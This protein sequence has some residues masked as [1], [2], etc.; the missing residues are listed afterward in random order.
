VATLV[1]PLHPQVSITFDPFLYL[2]VPLP[3]KQKVLPVFYFARE[4]HS[5]PIKVR[6]KSLTSTLGYSTESG[7]PTPL[8]V[9][10]LPQFLVSVS[11]ENSSAS[12][13]LDSLSQSVHVKPENLRL[14]E[15]CL[16]FPSLLNIWT[17]VCTYSIDNVC[18]HWHLYT[19]EYVCDCINTGF[20][21]L[22]EA[23]LKLSVGL[24]NRGASVPSHHQAL[25]FWWWILTALPSSDKEHELQDYPATCY[26]CASI[27]LFS[28]FISNLHAGLP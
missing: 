19:C 8:T 21:L 11:K 4:P 22:F 27:L 5:K 7:S 14:T 1:T 18:S 24:C 6:S 3:Q 2:P 17:C 28:H 12:E 13:V 15:V 9:S 23:L 10:L 20:V 26:G 16:S 25:F